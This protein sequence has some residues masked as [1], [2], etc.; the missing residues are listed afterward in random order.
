MT[1]ANIYMHTHKYTHKHTYTN[2]LYLYLESQSLS[3]I[4]VLKGKEKYAIDSQTTL[5]II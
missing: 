2:R 3:R 5:K 4:L 1:Y